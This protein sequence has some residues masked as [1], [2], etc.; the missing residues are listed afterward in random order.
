MV[1]SPS[2]LEPL[3]VEQE[4]TKLE[5]SLAGLAGLGA[6]KI[7]WLETA[8][9]QALL[10][11]L[12]QDDFHVFHFI[13]HG[14]YDQARDDGVLAFEDSTGRRQFVSGLELGTILSDEM[15]LP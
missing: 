11:R 13:G 8:T 14:G 6:V 15:S 12:R 3:D 5:D 7:D 1:S 9:L 2:D 10:R 4:R